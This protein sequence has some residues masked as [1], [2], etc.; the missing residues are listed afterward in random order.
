M[1][2]FKITDTKLL[3][4][5]NVLDLIVATPVEALYTILS[6]IIKYV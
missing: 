1:L 2:G 5:L 6:S 4:K 3:L